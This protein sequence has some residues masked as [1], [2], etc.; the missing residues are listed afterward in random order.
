MRVTAADAHRRFGID[1]HNRIYNVFGNLGKGIGKFDRR[2]HGK[3][4]GLCAAGKT[5]GRT[6]TVGNH[7][8]N[9]NSD[10]QGY[11]DDQRG[12]NPPSSCTH[13]DLSLNPRIPAWPFNL[14]YTTKQVSSP[15]REKEWMLCTPA[16]AVVAL[17]H[18]LPLDWSR[19]CPTPHLGN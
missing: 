16:R 8:A 14:E 5:F 15:P 18:A 1:A 12:Q 9:Q 7:G 17:G 4:L 19:R 6:N 13:L 11:S 10:P 3:R 2:G